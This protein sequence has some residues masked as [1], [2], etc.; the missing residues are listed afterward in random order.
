M[1]THRTQNDNTYKS[2]FLER[3]IIQKSKRIK[4]RISIK[5]KG[6][7]TTRNPRRIGMNSN[8]P[9]SVRVMTNVPFLSIRNHKPVHSIPRKREPKTESQPSLIIHSWSDRHSS[10]TEL[11][12]WQSSPGVSWKPGAN[13]GGLF[14]NKQWWQADLNHPRLLGPMITKKNY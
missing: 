8:C 13:L 6:C 5:V 4:V 14:I 11:S 9:L 7:L 1:N 2:I 10:C 12:Q 3:K